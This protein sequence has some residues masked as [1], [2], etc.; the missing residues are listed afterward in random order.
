MDSSQI[1]EQPSYAF[2]QVVDEH[3]SQ[4]HEDNR[5]IRRNLKYLWWLA[6]AAFVA[7]IVALAILIIEQI[8]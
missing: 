2:K 8:G 7:S 3:M 5:E 1:K 4:N 6:G